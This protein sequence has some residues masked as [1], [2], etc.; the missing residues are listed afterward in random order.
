MENHFVLLA[1]LEHLQTALELSA[2]H[3][4]LVISETQVMSSN[5]SCALKVILLKQRGQWLVQYAQLEL[6]IET[7]PNANHATWVHTRILLAS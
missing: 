4:P 1:T 6:F 5:A 3:A 7:V 2:S